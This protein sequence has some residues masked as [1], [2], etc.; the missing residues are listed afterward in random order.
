MNNLGI[1]QLPILAFVLIQG[2]SQQQVMEE[3]VRLMEQG[4]DHLSA[5]LRDATEMEDVAI[6]IGKNALVVFLVFVLLCLSFYP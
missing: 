4:N 5:A 1:H 3:Q 2:A 6:S